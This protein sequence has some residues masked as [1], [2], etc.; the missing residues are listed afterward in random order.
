MILIG[1]VGMFIIKIGR[2][3]WLQSTA[4]IWD[5]DSESREID[6]R[7]NSVAWRGVN[8]NSGGHVPEVGDVLSRRL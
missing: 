2:C 5:G 4:H 8:L 7:P 3:F 1:F 6:I